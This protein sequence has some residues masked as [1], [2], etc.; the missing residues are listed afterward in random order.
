MAR[1]GVVRALRQ[2]A[3]FPR[4][5]KLIWVVQPDAQKYSASAAGQINRITPPVS[6]N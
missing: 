2:N 1:D 6:P 4:R 5:I 3:N